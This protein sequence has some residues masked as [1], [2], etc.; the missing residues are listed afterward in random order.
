MGASQSVE[1]VR[2]RSRRR[3]SQEPRLDVES[4]HVLYMYGFVDNLELD[5]TS[6]YS[7][8]FQR[9]RIPGNVNYFTRFYVEN[10]DTFHKERIVFYIT[11]SQCT[12]VVPL[13]FKVNFQDYISTPG[14][15]DEKGDN[16]LKDNSLIKN[17]KYIYVIGRDGSTQ[18]N[19][20][21][22]NWTEW[23]NKLKSRDH[24]YDDAV[25]LYLPQL[26][27]SYGIRVKPHIMNE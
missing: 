22:D 9:I 4:C 13:K 21:K 7:D 2:R 18:W 12:L 17:W 5:I 25:Y 1:Q 19:Y 23:Q 20:I 15:Y 11:G 27:E 14:V 10:N 8:G 24:N 6:R 16:V 3:E 26:N